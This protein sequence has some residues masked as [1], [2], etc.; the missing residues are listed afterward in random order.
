MYSPSKRN[1]SLVNLCM[2]WCETIL[3]IFFVCLYHFRRGFFYCNLIRNYTRLVSKKITLHVVAARLDGLS[4]L[5]TFINWVS[6]SFLLLAKRSKE[7]IDRGGPQSR[8]S[9]FCL[10][11]ERDFSSLVLHY[12]STIRSLR[13]EPF[14]LHHRLRI[15]VL[16]DIPWLS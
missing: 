9:L 2:I 5:T 16:Q 4:L 8:K 13:W 6:Q 10:F 15:F 1:E 12:S 3:N 14:L 7:V 11:T